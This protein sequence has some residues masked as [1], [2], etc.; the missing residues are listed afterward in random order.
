MI[1]LHFDFFKEKKKNKD[2]IKINYLIDILI[3]LF[4]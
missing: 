3:Y 1:I 2:H 4:N